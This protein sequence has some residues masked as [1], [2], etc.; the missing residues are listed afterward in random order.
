[1][2]TWADQVYK[3]T[4]IMIKLNKKFAAISTSAVLAVSAIV[5][6]PMSALAADTV[7]IETTINNVATGTDGLSLAQAIEVATP[8][9]NE[10]NSL[11]TVR[12][13]I[14]ADEAAT[15][16]VAT[17]TGV[18]LVSKLNTIDAAIS[19][20]GGVSSLTLGT[21]AGVEVSFFAYTT[22]TTAGK[23]VIKVGTDAE[24][25][26]HI[27]G[28]AGPAY[29]LTASHPSKVDLGSSSKVSAVITDVFG[30]PID[31]GATVST[32][33]VN[34]TL[35]SF[36]YNAT[37]KKW[38]A[39]YTA[40]STLGE[41]TFSLDLNATAVTGLVAPADYYLGKVSVLDVTAL[42]TAKEAKEAKLI[43]RYNKL[44]KKWNKAFPNK[45][46]KMVK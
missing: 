24:V 26:Y 46:V 43:K 20:A 15:P 22:S 40:P 25:T 38:E 16:V 23:V 41:S 37:S 39:N 28:I 35:G 13:T 27:K 29:N 10:V 42:L 33:I 34:G 21:G 7:S 44:A 12:F 4:L 6:V 31:S 19:A 30:N 18:T 11:H 32:S 1:M 14:T 45:K 3:E 17:S 36:T 2:T 8:S 9:T 5:A